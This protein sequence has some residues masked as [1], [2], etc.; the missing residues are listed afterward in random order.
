[1]SVAGALQGCLRDIRYSLRQLRRM[2]GFSAVAILTLGLGIGANAAVFSVMN[3]IV[4]RYLPV[5]NPQQLVILHYT[6][7]HI[8]EDHAHRHNRIRGLAQP[9]QAN[10]EDKQDHVH[11]GEHILTYD[12]D[13]GP[14]GPQWRYVALPARTQRPDL[15]FCEPL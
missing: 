9:D 15:T 14:A 4:L 11:R 7:Q 2:P 10:A 8:E 6:N 1:M 3:A 5:A 12:L 13:R